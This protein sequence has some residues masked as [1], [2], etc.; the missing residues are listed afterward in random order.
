MNKA[1]VITNVAS[2]KLHP[3]YDSEVAD[4]VLYGM[5]VELVRQENDDWFYIETHYNYRGYINKKDILI[6]EKLIGIWEDKGNYV[7]SYSL[8]DVMSEASYSSHTIVMLTR[9]CIIA[10]TGIYDGKWEKILLP[11]GDF[12]WIRKGF[13][14]RVNKLSMQYDED[15][16]RT[17]IVA[18]AMSYMGTQYR[19]GGKSTLGIDCSGLSSMA[20]MLNGYIIPRDADIQ[21]NLLKPIKRDDAKPGDLFFFPGHVAVC[22]G[23][24][25]YV[26]S[27]GK[28]GYVL[29]NSFDPAH[30]DYREDLDRI[31]TGTGTLFGM[32]G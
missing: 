29:V 28:E 19:W 24:K 22:I 9:G 2:L 31:C 20:Y 4:E 32:E 16:L 23:G 10:E 25:R 30:E 3:A 14:S 21:Q 1:I 6:D 26:H 12:G 27:T 5:V 11:N 8:A 18:S 15:M 7:I 13:A 17:N